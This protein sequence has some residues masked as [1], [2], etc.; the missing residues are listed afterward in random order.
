MPTGVYP[1]PSVQERLEGRLVADGEHLLWNGATNADGYGI[2][3]INGK[4]RLAHRVAWEIANG[5]ISPRDHVLHRCDIPA[6]CAPGCLFLGDQEA[7]MADMASKGRHWQQ[8]K[9]FCPQ[10]HPYDEQNTYRAPGR[11]RRECRTC[12]ATKKSD[13]KGRTLS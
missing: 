1:R 5:P 9:D 8:R 7:N 2:I 12:R 4:T 3:R 6:C 13:Q 11:P 10:G